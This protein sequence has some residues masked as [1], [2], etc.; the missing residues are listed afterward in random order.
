M[1]NR[2]EKKIILDHFGRVSPE[3]RSI[4]EE[5]IYEDWFGE[6]IL[7][8]HLIFRSLCK[9]IVGQQL[10]GKAAEAIFK[11]FDEL[12]EGNV[13]P[14]RLLSLEE[15]QIRDVGLSWAKVR[16]VRDL[17]SRVLDGSLVLEKLETL[18]DEDL[19]GELSKVKGIGRW[20]AEM[21]LMFRLGREDIFSWGDLGLKNGLKK[22]LGN[23]EAS[24][25][26][27]QKVVEEWTPYRTYGAIAMWH[28]LDNR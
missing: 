19:I 26:E 10:A 1:T 15:Q 4:A 9:T 2:T 28:L 12:L 18:N 8:G 5:V 27:M 6:E 20:T 21:F 17:S 22:Y 16:S 3:L 25:E 13:T 7:D 14:E 11:R 23:K 24:L